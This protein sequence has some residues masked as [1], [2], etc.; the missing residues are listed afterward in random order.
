MGNF[1]LGLMVGTIVG[2]GV[3]MTVHPMN[4]RSMKRAYHR[5]ER[6][7]NRMTDAIHNIGC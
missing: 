4:K 6:M 2:V 7:M 3:M 1:S 5:A